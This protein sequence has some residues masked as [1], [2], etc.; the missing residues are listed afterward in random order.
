MN[1][2]F[3][4]ICIIMMSFIFCSCVFLYKEGGSAYY[5]GNR[6]D[7]FRLALNSFPGPRQGRGAS[8]DENTIET[9]EFG[10]ELY[11]VNIYHAGEFY[12]WDKEI[13]VNAAYVI[14]QAHDS[15]KIYYYEDICFRLFDDDIGLDKSL[16][17]GLK[18]DNDWNQPLHL[19]KCASRLYEGDF[20]GMSNLTFDYDAQ[21]SI[22][23]A[24]GKQYSITTDSK[25]S[26]ISIIPI[27][28]DYSGKE[29]YGVRVNKDDKDTCFMVIY[30]P[31]KEFDMENNVLELTTVDFGE[32]LHQFKIRNDW[33][34]Q[35][36]PVEHG[37]QD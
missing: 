25:Q 15:N 13:N 5:S 31:E 37:G 35:R 33:D 6:Y 1:K 27:T 29:I 9:D 26:F 22:K 23:N 10:R 7:L 28:E 36:C 11:I 17:E 21:K 12:G 8:I 2:V 34:F 30:H 18:T 32:E 19:E 24:F 14:L 20:A 16:L 3:K 4:H